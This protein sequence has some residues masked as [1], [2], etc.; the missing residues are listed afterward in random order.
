M[1][2]SEESKKDEMPDYLKDL[3]LTPF[4][5]RKAFLELTMEQRIDWLAAMVD[6]WHQPGMKKLRGETD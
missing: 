3:D 4:D 5:T 2:S 6:F 1:K